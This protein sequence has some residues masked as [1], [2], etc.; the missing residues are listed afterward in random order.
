MVRRS[1]RDP[2]SRTS[3]YFAMVRG[4]AS[5]AIHPSSR[6]S[7]DTPADLVRPRGRQVDYTKRKLVRSTVTAPSR[8]DDLMLSS[9]SLTCV[10][11]VAHGTLV[12]PI[13]G[14][15]HSLR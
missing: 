12:A 15:L 5:T 1:I 11:A 6:P 14:I 8:R 7:S 3:G 2:A 13:G 4:N 9:G 10:G